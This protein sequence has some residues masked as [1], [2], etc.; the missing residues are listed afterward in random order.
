MSVHPD[1]GS[2]LLPFTVQN[3]EELLFVL[4]KMTP[5]ISRQLEQRGF[6][7]V[8][9]TATGWYYFFSKDRVVY[10]DDLRC[11]TLWVRTGDPN[12]VAA[13]W[14][15]ATSEAFRNLAGR[16][17]SRQAHDMVREYIEEFRANQE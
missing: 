12:E 3:D 1:I 14:R 5:H 2:L 10:P 13:Q 8:A 11:Q 16:S 7:V 17:F 6:R 15:S 4:E 9:W